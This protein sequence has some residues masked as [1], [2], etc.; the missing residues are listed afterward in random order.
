MLIAVAGLLA[1]GM[2]ALALALLSRRGARGAARPGAP[3]PAVSILKPLKGIDD[4]LE[5]NLESFFRLDYPDYE[6]VFGI[7]DRD[8]PAAAVVDR[9]RARHP[10]RR[11]FLSRGLHPSGTNPK[12]RNLMKMMELAGGGLIV[13][14]DSNTRVRPEYLRRSVPCF[15]D[16]RVALVSHF[17]SA[18]GERTTGALLDNLHVSGF[19]PVAQAFASVYAGVTPIIGKSMIIRRSRL[20]QAG[21]FGAFADYLAEDYLLGRKLSRAGG[22]IMILPHTVVNWGARTTLREFCARHFRWLS[23]RWR[24]NPASCLVEL[25]A[26]TTLWASLWLATAPRAWPWAALVVAL[27]L[28]IQHAVVAS[29]RGGRGMSLASLPLS[30]VKEVLHAAILVASAFGD[31]VRWRGA[32][33]RIG[34]RTKLTPIGARPAAAAGAPV[35]AASPPGGEAGARPLSARERRSRGSPLHQSPP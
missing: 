18:E 25:G 19:I 29:L 11:C 1:Y 28:A 2:G 24:I 10:D 4:G 15:E 7:A 17:L 12:V 13:V 8:D 35:L 5:E 9:L 31:R 3:L 30:P 6:I 14:S 33:Y 26:N 16:P 21:G 22:A 27:R 32:L 20:E 34:W 23:M